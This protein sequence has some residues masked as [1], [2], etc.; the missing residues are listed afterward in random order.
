MTWEEWSPLGLSLLCAFVSA[1]LVLPWGIFWGWLLARRT[2][3]GRRV[4][5]VLISLP[6][7]LPP[8]LTGY[9]LLK[10]L[11]K[12]AVLGRWLWETLHLR[13]VLDWKGAALASAVVASPFM[14]HMVKQAVSRIDPRL[15][16][17]ARSLG[18]G[19]GR[20]FWTVTL[21]LTRPALIGGFFLV[22]ARSLGEFGA[23]IMVAGNIP[24][25]TQTIPLAIY[26]RVYLGQESA[27]WP[28]IIAAVLFS[29]AGLWIGT[30]L[31]ARR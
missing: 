2:F 13:F 22:L 9:F 1:V 24:G 10:I 12:N 8:V 17:A 16:M 4:V 14:V 20:V 23:T 19:P 30:A 6:L 27:I 29:Y 3:P 5:E 7:V 15:E 25:K 31:E 18:A 28:L 26:Q 11:G 21:P